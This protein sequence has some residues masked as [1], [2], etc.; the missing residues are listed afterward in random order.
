MMQLAAWRQAADDPLR[1]ALQPWTRHLAI[2]SL[3]R[4]AVRGAIAGLLA[5]AAVLCV[6][7]VVPIAEADL[8][9]LALLAALPFLLAGL[10]VGAWPRS[11]LRRAWQLD[12]RL[13]LADRL[14]TAW[15]QRDAGGPMPQR[16]RA[17]ALQRLGARSPEQELPLRW[18]RVELGTLLGCALLAALFSVVRSPMQSVLDQR[19]AEA[20]SVQAA[21]QQLEA[22]RQQVA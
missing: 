9:P 2:E 13:A 1:L 12:R 18:N 4:W 17:D 20:A 19:A 15:L 14:T 21:A 11:M 22:L 5:A 16:Q 8:R 10:T 3:A 6:G 7:W